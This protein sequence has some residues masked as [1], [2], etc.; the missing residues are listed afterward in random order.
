VLSH[1]PVQE[2]ESPQLRVPPVEV[3]GSVDLSSLALLDPCSL[4]HCRGLQRA[5][6][7]FSDGDPSCQSCLEI[8]P[9]CSLELKLPSSS[10]K[11]G[12]HSRNSTLWEVCTHA[13]LLLA[14]SI[15][16]VPCEWSHHSCVWQAMGLGA[17]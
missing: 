15:V 5:S 7:S 17:H 3:E 2:E 6:P 16:V 10:P 11:E 9:L 4:Y 1:S 13:L 14:S 8:G 12:M